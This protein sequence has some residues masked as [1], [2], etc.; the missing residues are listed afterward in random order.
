M[1]GLR[2]EAGGRMSYDRPGAKLYAGQD[3]HA[4][5]DA[6]GVVWLDLMRTLAAP[7]PLAGEALDIGAGTG[8][9]TSVLKH[10][11]MTVTGLE[12][13]QDMIDQGLEE[14]ASLT[15]ED[16]ALGNAEDS[17]LFPP[18]RFDWIVSRQVLCHL[19]EVERS[20]TAWRRW[21][22]PGG[23]VIVVDG[24]WG[25]SGWG[26]AALA[27][28]P[29]AALTR[30]DPVADALARAGFDIL[31]AGEFDEVNAARRAV[32]GQSTTRYVA[33]ARKG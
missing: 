19:T 33:V 3:E 9:L 7:Q 18:D 5:P 29:F 24:F 16:F 2:G 6:E 21:L 25:R 30:A 32:F 1:R 31:R 13:S 12:Q 27:A 28:Q 23:H 10:A 14:D 11:G 26:D 15:A 20:F 17:T 4:L 22:K 8:L